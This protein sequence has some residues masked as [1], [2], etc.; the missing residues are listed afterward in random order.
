MSVEPLQSYFSSSHIHYAIDEKTIIL[1][2]VL[3]W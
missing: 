2:D 3:Q 1:E